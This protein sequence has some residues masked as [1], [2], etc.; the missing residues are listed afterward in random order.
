MSLDDWI[1]CQAPSGRSKS[2][3]SGKREATSSSTGHGKQGPSGGLGPTRSVVALSGSWLLGQVCRH[4]CVA[5]GRR[6]LEVRFVWIPLNLPLLGVT[7]PA[8]QRG[9]WSCT[10]SDKASSPGSSTPRE[11]HASTLCCLKHYVIEWCNKIILPQIGWRYAQYNASS[12]WLE[13]LT[14]T[15]SVCLVNGSTANWNTSF[16]NSSIVQF[17][18]AYIILQFFNAYIILQFFG[19]NSNQIELSI[20]SYLTKAQRNY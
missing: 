3:R 6:L 19:E 14:V 2:S 17:L 10:G 12:L 20:Y 9:G 15:K 16:F 4:V 7:E 11:Q 5:E 1:E 18:N 13:L 8:A